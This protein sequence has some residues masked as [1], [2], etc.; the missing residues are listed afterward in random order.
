MVKPPPG[1]VHRAPCELEWCPGDGRPK[2]LAPRKGGE[3]GEAESGGRY[4][5]GELVEEDTEAVE[6]GGEG[7]VE[8]EEWFLEG[9]D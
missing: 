3:V 4:F 9:F 2:G 6:G 5:Q 1:F 8:D 7:E